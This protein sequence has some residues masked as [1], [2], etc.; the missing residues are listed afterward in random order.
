MLFYDKTSRKLP[1]SEVYK[2]NLPKYRSDV[3]YIVGRENGLRKC[4]AIARDDRTGFYEK[5]K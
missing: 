3:E 1:K 5:C 2:I 4:L